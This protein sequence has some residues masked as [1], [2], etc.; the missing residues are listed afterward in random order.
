MPARD[1]MKDWGGLLAGIAA[2]AG[3][4]LTYVQTLSNRDQATTQSAKQEIQLEKA[5]MLLSQAVNR[6][7][8]EAQE[9]DQVIGDMREAIGEIRGAIAHVN[10]SAERTLEG[11]GALNRLNPKKD[12]P[13]RAPA[14]DGDGVEEASPPPI[15]MP[16]QLQQ[17]LPDVGSEAVEQRVL[18]MKGN[19]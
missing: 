3:V 2:L 19:G 10:R 17:E 8:S 12:K 9:R 6:L 18:I 5:Y 11:S 1:K 4:G 13:A 7:A 16:I 15:Q 14:S